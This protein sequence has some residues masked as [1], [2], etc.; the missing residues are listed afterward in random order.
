EEKKLKPNP[1]ADK[2]TLLR[3]ASLDLTGLPPS[4]DEV[5]AFLSDN[6]SDAFAKV[7]D[8]LLASPHYG[9]RWGRHWL[10]LARYADSNG[11]KA[12]A[13]RPHIWRYRRYL[14]QALHDDQLYYQV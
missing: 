6:S 9:E 13:T 3:R 5:Q 12:D 2:I 1:P 4:P 10:D 7:V 11:F 14:I 8:R